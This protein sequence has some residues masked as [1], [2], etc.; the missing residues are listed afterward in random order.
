[1]IDQN[2]V[3]RLLSEVKFPGSDKDIV[4]FGVVRGCEVSKAG[5]VTLACEVMGADES[6]AV[7]VEQGI[8][9]RLAAA[10][11]RDV[12]VDMKFRKFGLPSLDAKN[13]PKAPLGPHGTS[14]DPWADRQPIEGVAHVIAVASGKGGVGKSTVAV[15]LA[16]ALRRK[17]LRVGLMDADIYGPSEPIMLGT[18]AVETT[19][20]DGKRLNPIIAHGLKTMSIG[21]I[22][23][24]G[25]PVIWRGPMVMKMISQFLRDVN[26]GTLDVLVIDLPPGTGDV[27]LSL[28]QKV[29]LDGVIIVTTPQDVALAD[30]R[31]GQAMFEK[32]EVP[33]LGVVEN[34]SYYCCPKCN[35]RSE[36]FSH[37]GGARMA[38]DLKLDV[39]AEIPLDIEIRKS[40]DAGN[41]VVIADPSGPHATEFIKLAE[42]VTERV[43]RPN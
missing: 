12:R 35:H 39:L 31:R 38:A 41:P 34:M 26:W 36:I 13:A 18:G 24:D 20:D 32:V 29:P 4:S 10:G 14:P 6:V 23:E 37:G 28:V 25:K 1:M 3:L 42:I 7:T 5:L 15:N 40:M 30:V 27:Q 2:F 43:I 22:V 16:L 9:E 8:R 33:I 17:G 11:L 19:S 21:Y